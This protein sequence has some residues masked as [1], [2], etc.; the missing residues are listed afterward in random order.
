[1]DNFT[2]KR[3]SN[4]PTV[5]CEQWYEIPVDVETIPFQVNLPSLNKP[6]LE[7]LNQKVL[8]IHLIVCLLSEILF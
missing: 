3:L 6:E 4:D 7:E 5:A 8:V 1:M 2:P